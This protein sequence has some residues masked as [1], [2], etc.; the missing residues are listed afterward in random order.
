MKIAQSVRMG[1]WLLIGLN[2]LMALG[3][4]WVFTRMSPA[5]EVIIAR[6]EN[7]LQACE[8]MLAILAMASLDT[9]NKAEQT[10]IF[11]EA[12][13]WA[14][15]NITEQ[16]ERTAIETVEQNFNMA[17]HGKPMEI[18]RTVAAITLL[19]KINREAM[20][21]ADQKAKQVGSAGAWGVVF[22]AAGVFFVGMLFKR[23]LNSGLVKPLEEIHAVISAQRNGDTMRRCTGVDL[24][25]DVKTVFDGF[26]D[27]LDK[28]QNSAEH[29]KVIKFQV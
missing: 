25:K 6:N 22:M 14:R 12:L 29:L 7:S 8:Q 23:S 9:D 4:I 18:K 17:L 3:S 24:P 5:I 21:K 13:E 10:A 2:L 15:Y 11:S 16:E 28:N 27:Y 19:G 1:A 20:I 26:N